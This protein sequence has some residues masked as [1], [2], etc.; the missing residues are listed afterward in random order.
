MSKP[1]SPKTRAEI[2]ALLETGFSKSATA[3]QTGV[4]LSSVKRI[5]KDSK[6]KLGKKHPELVE[7]A[8]E[9]LY[10]ALSSDFVKKQIASLVIDDLSLA[11]SLRDNLAT[12]TTEVEEMEVNGWKDAVAKTRTLAGIATASKLNS[13]NLRQVLSLAAPNV[14]VE[15]IP[16]LIMTD[17][18]QEEVETIREQQAQDAIKMGIKFNNEAA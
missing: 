17:M 9:A 13:D 18:T 8:E 7:A 16:E 11:A 3:R 15:E 12:L 10:S 14:E 6:V 2:I 5:A 4:S 1:I